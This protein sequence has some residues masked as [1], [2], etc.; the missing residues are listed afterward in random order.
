[1]S[2]HL[3][4]CIFLGTA[5][6]ILA[7]MLMRRD[8][9]NRSPEQ[10][11][12]LNAHSISYRYLNQIPSLCEEETSPLFQNYFCNVFPLWFVLKVQFEKEA[13]N[14][15]LIIKARGNKDDALHWVKIIAVFQ[16][17]LC[18][19]PL[20]FQQMACTHQSLH[21]AIINTAPSNS[22]QKG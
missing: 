14:P 16:D 19:R 6:S 17:L 15:N 20:K 21:C 3:K 7:D 2:F 4:H 8:S 12:Y 5:H 1:M 9:I 13:P 11:L 10:S 22:C 18:K